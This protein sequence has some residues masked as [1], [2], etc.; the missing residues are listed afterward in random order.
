MSFW[1]SALLG[2]I[3]AALFTLLY[4]ADVL[5]PLE[6]Q[7]YDFFLGFRSNRPH[8]DSVVFLDVDD[9]AIAYNGIFPWPRSIPAEGLL[10]LKEHGARAAIFDI[11]YI[12]RG[13]QG[14][15]SLYLEQ[16]LP[17][18]FE[19]SFT[20]IGAAADDL[21]SALKTGRIQ[22]A[23]LDDYAR[24]LYSYINSEHEGLFTKAQGVARD[25][26]RYLAQAI[27]LFGRSW[28]TL[29]LRALPLDGEQAERRPIAEE[30][31]AYPV[32][33]AANAHRGKNVDVL[34]PLP[35]FAQAAMGA[36]FTNAEVDGDG[37]RRRIYLT[38][39]IHDHWYLQLAF[40]PLID[41]LGRPDIMLKRQKLTIKQAQM[42]DGSI[43]DIDIPLDSRGRIMLDWPKENYFESY[44][45]ISFAEFSQ[46]DEIDAQ[47][48]QY[49]RALASA[50]VLFFARFDPSL[51]RVLVILGDLEELFDAANRAKAHAMENCSE[52]SFEAYIGYRAQSRALFAQ[53][54]ELDVNSKIAAALDPLCEEYPESAVAIREEA[55]YITR[56][57]DYITIN[58]ALESK[59][60]GRID[61]IVRG[62]F[63]I[64]GRCD[65][66]TTDLGSNSFWSEYINVG[67][68][69][70]V[71]DM[72]LSESFITYLNRL[73][74]VLFMV[75]FVPLFFLA[76]ARLSPIPRAITGF[77]AAALFVAI[78]L[79]MF[80]F[81]GVF[82]SPLAAVFALISAAIVREI[83]S[84]A[85]SEKE[86]SFIRTA[87]ST[88]L[89]GDVVK[90]IIADPSRMQ[91]GGTKRSMTAVFTDVKDFSVVSEK[92]DPEDL[93]S[94]LN[95]YL[96]AMS[97][98]ILAEKGTIDKYEGDAIIAFFGAPL[99]L[100]DH[101]LR[102]CISAITMK[103]FEA[104]LNKTI[105]QQKLSPAPLLTRIGINT[106]SMVVGNMGTQN[107]MNYTIMGNAVNLASRLEGVNKQYG[108]WILASDDTVRETGG[109]LLTRKLDRVRV[110]GI[111][112]PVRL[113]ELVETMEDAAG[114]QHRLVQI[115]H[116]A[117]ERFEERDW[118]QAATGFKEALAI[119][120]DDTPSQMYLQ[121]CVNFMQK[122]PQDG[123]DGVYNL[124]EK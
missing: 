51:R 102:A 65:T 60:R 62:R 58:V 84:Y 54:L 69:G 41:Y 124:T 109:R 27:E 35:M 93:V 10:R 85:D 95:R 25:N 64:L 79:V 67:T 116:A 16:G 101:A 89:S 59:T 63:C 94:L 19:R 1:K 8:I 86:K 31:F 6:N 123:W 2:L 23:D 98:I 106:G 14:V 70:V 40:A 15:D 7:L 11:E 88:Y 68:H 57:I 77:A 18:D 107:K 83:M 91:L 120:A 13:P 20:G 119:K 43:K 17:A 121:R 22:N 5:S 82:L 74:H 111:N 4:L 9:T 75:I 55:E 97:D 47:L 44:R 103:R 72:I 118:K 52:D 71:L 56:L 108:T 66:G 3:S 112:E 33:A 49:N 92:L 113:H 73:W 37:I 46:L 36:G 90:E 21:F 99:V 78:P 114:S 110:V 100:E 96:S 48:E 104:E 24:S 32:N 122:P 117:L 76:S 45:H 39:N 30:R 12:D 29:N 28:L 87:F 38:Q 61:E 115:F 26:D 34:P 50:D 53:L 42:P 80:K 105:I 81:T